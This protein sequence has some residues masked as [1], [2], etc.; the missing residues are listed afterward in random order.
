MKKY[1]LSSVLKVLFVLIAIAVG[2]L[3]A[4]QAR[5][6]EVNLTCTLPTLNEDGSEL[7]DLESIR[8]YEST[9]SGGPYTLI[10]ETSNPPV[11]A[12]TVQRDPG[13][14]YYVGTAVNSSGTASRNS[15]EASKEVLPSIP[16]PPTDL[17]TSGNLVAYAIQMSPDVINT[18]PVGTVPAGIPCDGGMS[19]NGF[20][21]V[22]V[23][24]VTFAGQASA[25]VVVAEC[26]AG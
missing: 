24:F 2:F 22:D 16:E 23:A 7:V 18:Y 9:V 14:Y 11:C 13:T 5:A 17:V 1:N 26:S 21:R 20:N 15:G 25:K 4:T 10:G 8:F 6:G 3:Y 12:F 19:A